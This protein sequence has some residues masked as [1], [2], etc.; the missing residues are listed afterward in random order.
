M[1]ISVG[2][3]TSG[4]PIME[5]KD[6][7]VVLKNQRIGL[8]FHWERVITSRLPGEVK[9]TGDKVFRV[10]NRVP[11]ETYLACVVGSEMNPNAPIEFLKAHAIISRSWAV[12]KIIN[13]HSADPVGK[14]NLLTEIIDWED[15]CDHNGFDVCADDHCQ[16]YQ[17][18]QPMDPRIVEALR[19]TEGLCLYSPFGKLIDTR[20]SK[21][22]GGRTE[23]FST[24]WQSRE[25]DCLK[26]LYDPWCDLSGL[27]RKEKDKVLKAILKDYDLENGGGYGWKAAITAREIE[28][29][30]L[31]KFN[32]NVGEIEELRVEERGESG[33]AKRLRIIGRNGSLSIGKELMIRRL[34]A[35]T[36]LYSSWIDITRSAR[37][38]DIFEIEGHGWGHGVGL[39]QIGA[40][41]MALEGY[42]F[43]EILYFYYPG[44]IIE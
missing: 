33:R 25:E 21:C 5:V 20:F 15:T 7:Y 9:I 41:R 19:E 3:A 2:I 30:L 10:I 37:H 27:N 14:V 1:I 8:G 6:D 32:R 34:L 44:C 42:N 29:N 38:S 28:N 17:G 40:A 16:R 31:T 36:H 18:L 23:V 24:C 35:P 13:A 12:G 4:D 39:C 43:K 11:L 26:S 22:C